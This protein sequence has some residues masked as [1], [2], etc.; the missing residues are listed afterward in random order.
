MKFLRGV[1]RT[2]NFGTNRLEALSDGVFAIVITLL[3]LEIHIPQV[4][5]TNLS[6]SC[7]TGS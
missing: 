3:I 4:A 7:F 5:G 2:G 6:R 1:L